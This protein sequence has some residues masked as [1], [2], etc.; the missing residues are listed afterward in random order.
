MFGISGV[1]CIWYASHALFGLY[2]SYASFVVVMVSTVCTVGLVC[3]VYTVCIGFMV[4]YD[5]L[6][7]MYLPLFADSKK[8]D[9]HN[10][11][12]QK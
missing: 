9:Y 2:A 3:L 7:S 8:L 4:P 12:F 1:H 10:L 11:G 6:P 5:M